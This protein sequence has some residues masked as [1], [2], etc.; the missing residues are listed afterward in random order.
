MRKA[1]TVAYGTAGMP[2][3]RHA[4]LPASR[5]LPQGFS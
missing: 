1:A 3:A 5:L 2:A 4:R